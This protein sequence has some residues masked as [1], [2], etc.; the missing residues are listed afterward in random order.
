M[1]R[2]FVS[3]AGSDLGA[4]EMIAGWLREAGHRVFLDR[5][6]PVADPVGELRWA[7]NTAEHELE[8]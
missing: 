8:C 1:A 4:A 6:L 7:A 2:V 3:H 5:D